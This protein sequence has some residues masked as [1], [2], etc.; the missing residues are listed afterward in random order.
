MEAISGN[1]TGDT[2]IIGDLNADGS[3]YNEENIMHFTDWN[4]VITNDIDT[5]VGASDNTYDRVIIN[6]AC[7]NNYFSSDVMDEV[8][9]EQSDH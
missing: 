9:K 4:W 6:E 2:I 5:T 7:E 3:Y 1:P 8:N